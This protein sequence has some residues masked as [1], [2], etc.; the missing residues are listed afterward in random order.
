M[1]TFILPV[2]KMNYKLNKT[3]NAFFI[4]NALLKDVDF[5]LG[6]MEARNHF[7]FGLKTQSTTI[8]TITNFF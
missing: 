1:I 8:F 6:Y 7:G 5:F 2:E 4:R 3:K